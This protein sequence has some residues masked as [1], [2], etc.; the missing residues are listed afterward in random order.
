MKY[1]TGMVVEGKVTGIQPYGAFVSLDNQNAGLIHI[2]EISDGFVKDISKYVQVG[3]HVK[4]KIVDFDKKHHQAR[5]SL[6]ALNKPRVRKSRRQHVYQK[7]SLPSMKLG[8][9]SIAMNM[10][11]W[12]QEAKVNILKES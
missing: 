6:K 3:D 9:Q 8:F 12:I 11:Q 4:V 7:P 10:D 1:K 2:S 5:L